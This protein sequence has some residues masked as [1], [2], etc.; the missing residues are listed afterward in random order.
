LGKRSQ[1]ERREKDFY[2]T[3]LHAAL[4][5]LPHLEPHTRF[6]EPCAGKRDLIFH[7]EADGHQCIGAHD[8]VYDPPVDARIARYDI[9]DGALIVTN[10]PYHG[11]RNDLHALIRNLSDQAPVWLLMPADWIHNRSSAPLM[12]RL[13]KIVSV[14]RVKWIAG[15]PHS[16]FE[17]AVWLLFDSP[18]DQPPLFYGRQLRARSQTQ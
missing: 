11:A 3:P 9:P 15:T 12:P 16:S 13:K 1:F 17:N 2:P 4:P 10:P 5:L 14:G 6:E 8:I 7:L 18:G